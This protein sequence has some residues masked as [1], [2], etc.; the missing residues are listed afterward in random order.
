MG[1]G[2]PQKTLLFLL[3]KENKH[4]LELTVIFNTFV[5]L[6]DM[7]KLFLEKIGIKCGFSTAHKR[8]NDCIFNK[9]QNNKKCN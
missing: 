3:F 2:G 8:Q 6:L 7:S 4:F 5:I 9:N 1:F